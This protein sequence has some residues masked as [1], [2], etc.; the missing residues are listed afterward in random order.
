MKSFYAIGLI[1]LSA[2]SSRSKADERPNV[3]F[4]M[5]DQ[6]SYNMMS[7]TGNKW[8]NTP[9]MDKISEMGYRFDKNYSVNP[10]CMPARFSFQT[11]QYASEVG[12]KENTSAYDKE[13]VAEIVSESGVGNLFRKAGYE[14]LYSGKLHL[15]GTRNMKE[16]GY[17]LHGEDPYDGPA[18]YAEKAFS[19]MAASGSE[20]PFFMFLSFMN[21]HDI[22]YKAGFD[23][24]FPDELEEDKARETIRLLD[25]Q[26]SMGKREYQSQ[27]PPRPD[28]LQ[29]IERESSDM[30]SMSNRWRDW[31]EWQWDL[32]N[33]MYHRLTESVDAQIG[34]VLD[35][36]EESGL[37]ENT[38]IV[39]TSDHGDMNGAH[40]MILKNVMFEECQRV[41]FIFA[42]KGI[43]KDYVDQN[44]LTCNGLDLVPTLCDLAGVE[45]PDD[46][47][48][49]SLK[50]YLTG[51]GE[52]PDRKYIITESYNAYQINDGRHKYTIYE[53]PGHPELLTDIKSNPGETINFVDDPSYAGIKR[54]LKQ[55]LMTNLEKR[56]L[57]PLPVDRQIENIR[58]KEKAVKRNQKTS[59]D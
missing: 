18:E 59:E 7:C 22:C 47:P 4:I 8:L 31:E 55:E 34:R 1:L 36:L 24:R 23:S 35:A 15:Y 11:G 40:G 45:Y 39:F 41:P 32:Y 48:G 20:K 16:Y 13:K 26:K 21:P 38:I 12:V 49:V 50:P 14:T 33:W 57:L 10:V 27:V 3:L 19:E 25:V 58:A 9:N 29:P 46:L 53:L 43:K 54:Q 44:T 30:V 56:D 37:R 42:G 52:K 17:T 28:N 5:T 2:C 6:Q 51:K